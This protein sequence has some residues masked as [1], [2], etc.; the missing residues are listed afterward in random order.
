MAYLGTCANGR[1]SD[2]RIA[3]NLLRGKK[4]HSSVRFYVSPISARVY[5]Q[6][7]EEGLLADL[8]EAG[9]VILPSS[10]SP[11]IGINLV[12]LG[13]GDVALSTGPRNMQ[14]RMGSK[15]AEI[16]TANP[17]VVACSVLTGEITD[18]REFI[19]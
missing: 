14:G 11:C 3:A 18:P 2:I 13:R 1:L 15:E 9:A 12:I 10:C 6:A 4:I 17:L 19:R 8:A 5:R 7:L 16:Y